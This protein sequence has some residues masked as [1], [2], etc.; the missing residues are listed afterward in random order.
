MIRLGVNVDHVATVRQARG[1]RQPDPV[2]AAYIAEMSGADMITIHLREDRRHIQERD[3]FL[4]RDTVG[5]S[6]NLEMAAV[7]EIIAIALEAKPDQVT[8]V[9]E[10][11]REVTTEGGLDV[12]SHKE[13]IKKA[14]KKFQKAD[15]RVSLFVNPDEKI[16]RASARTGADMVELH[17]GEYANAMNDRD[18]ETALDRLQ[19]AATLAKSLGLMVSAGHGLDY[20][21]VLPI[22]KI[23]EIQE[24]NIGHS[25][26]ARAIFVG[27]EQA[28]K[29]MKYLLSKGKEI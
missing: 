2:A 9:P 15:I 14:T 12:I 24:V 18:R 8:F 21:N 29:E 27:V 22:R 25:I 3:L 7:D 19:K 10:R 26:V 28:V 4:L 16:I 5:T 20:H 13:R 1:G 17:T 23:K 6:L 11:R